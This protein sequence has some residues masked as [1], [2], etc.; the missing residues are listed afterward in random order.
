MQ[1]WRVAS[2]Y[3]PNERVERASEGHIEKQPNIRAWRLIL[4]IFTQREIDRSVYSIYTQKHLQLHTLGLSTWKKDFLL[5]FIGEFIEKKWRGWYHF[6]L[7]VISP[8]HSRAISLQGKSD[9]TLCRTDI[10]LSRWYHQVIYT[11]Y[12]NYISPFLG[13]KT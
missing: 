13:I 5:K 12:I 1:G 8:H 10:T 3:G 2:Q 7:V 6:Y 4:S 11:G 9:I